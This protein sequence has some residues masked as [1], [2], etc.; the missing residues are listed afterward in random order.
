MAKDNR[1]DAKTTKSGGVEFTHAVP[2]T[3]EEIVGRTGTRGEAT[4]VRVKI[5]EG[6]DATKVIRRNVRGPRGGHAVAEPG[7]RERDGRDGERLARPRGGRGPRP[8]RRGRVPA[9]PVHGAHAGRRLLR[10][11]GGRAPTS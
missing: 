6:R 10:R 1:K 11:S 5:L 9:P 4:Q 7:Q 8:R 3:I 2:A